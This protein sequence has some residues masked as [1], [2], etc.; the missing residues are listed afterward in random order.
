MVGIVGSGI[1]QCGQET[2]FSWVTDARSIY[3][4]SAL[5]GLYL[6]MLSGNQWAAKYLIA[7][8]TKIGLEVSTLM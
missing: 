8:E 5:G 2:L 7:S 6:G 4:G 1:R 3:K